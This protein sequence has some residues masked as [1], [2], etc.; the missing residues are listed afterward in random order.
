MIKPLDKKVCEGCHV[1]KS[2]NLFPTRKKKG[3]PYVRRKCKECHKAMKRARYAINPSYAARMK[4][5]A[6]ANREHLRAYWKEY[7]EKHKAKRHAD[8]KRQRER[9]R[10]IISQRR[11]DRYR[12]NK[13]KICKAVS[14]Y[15]KRNRPAINKR[16]REYQAER[17]KTDPSFKLGI[18]LRA[19]IKTA[20]AKGYKKAAK[21]TELLGCSVAELKVHLENQFQPGMSWENQGRYGW[22]IDHIIPCAAFDLSNEDEQRRCFHYSNL[23]PLWA[24]DNMKKGAKILQSKH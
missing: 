5:Y 9:D 16:Q 19:R 2:I 3:V 18:T 6:D 23:Q 13:E 4:R 10:E 12:K 15:A 21:T 17:K 7:D 20:L 22:H 24:I 14:D 1:E 11:K 8:K